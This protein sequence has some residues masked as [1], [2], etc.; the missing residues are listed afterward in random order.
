MFHISY[1]Y[2][3]SVFCSLVLFCVQVVLSYFRETS[4]KKIIHMENN[5]KIQTEDEQKVNCSLKKNFQQIPYSMTLSKE[6]ISEKSSYVDKQ[7]QNLKMQT[8]LSDVGRDEIVSVFV[9]TSQQ[10]QDMVRGYELKVNQTTDHI[11]CLQE[12]ISLLHNQLAAKNRMI[13]R[14]CD[15]YLTLAKQKQFSEAHL[16]RR[17]DELNSVIEACVQNNRLKLQKQLVQ[18]INHSRHLEY[19]NENLAQQI[20]KICRQKIG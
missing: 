13:A 8:S 5:Y 20:K 18:Q 16:Q 4:K 12:H 11:S 3:L 10:L 6:L 14:M 17:I 9:R 15:Q 2:Y 7:N 19:Q 1:T